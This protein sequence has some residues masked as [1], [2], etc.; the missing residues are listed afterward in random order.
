MLYL[1]TALSVFVGAG[2]ST[3]LQF[4]ALLTCLDT[5]LQHTGNLYRK[6]FMRSSWSGLTESL[7]ALKGVRVAPLIIGRSI[8]V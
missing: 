7:A 8:R 1:C 2:L 6:A 4:A 3:S 5:L